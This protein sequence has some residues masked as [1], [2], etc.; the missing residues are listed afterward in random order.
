MQVVGHRPLELDLGVKKI[1]SKLL[2][3]IFM[4]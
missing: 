2:K 4:N 3:I 1:V